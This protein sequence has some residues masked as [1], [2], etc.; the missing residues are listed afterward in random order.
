MS[1]R[2]L[3]QHQPLPVY[4]HLQRPLPCSPLRRC[5]RQQNQTELP[6]RRGRLPASSSHCFPSR[7]PASPQNRC[8]SSCWTQK[9]HLHQ[10]RHPMRSS[11]SQRLSLYRQIPPM[12][13]LRSHD[14]LQ[15]GHSDLCR[16][17]RLRSNLT[18]PLR[19]S[20]QSPMRSSPVEVHHQGLGNQPYRPTSPRNLDHTLCCL[21]TYHHHPMHRPM[22]LNSSHGFLPY[23]PKPPANPLR[24]P[25]CGQE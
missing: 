7:R 25:N 17:N 11:S 5:L 16:R 2:A 23:H 12:N 10:L 3:F 8:H 6:E 4:I 20:I 1:I 13:S 15:R 18:H 21:Q 22:R 24:R 9:R 14:F 19:N